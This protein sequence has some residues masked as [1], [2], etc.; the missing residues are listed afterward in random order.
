MQNFVPWVQPVC[1][2]GG[3]DGRSKQPAKMNINHFQI[4]FVNL[5]VAS[6]ET[7]NRSHNFETLTPRTRSCCKECFCL[8]R[9]S[10]MQP[11]NG[12]LRSSLCLLCCSQIKCTR[13]ICDTRLGQPQP[14]LVLWDLYLFLV[15]ELVSLAIS[16]CSRSKSNRRPPMQPQVHQI[17][18]L[19][20]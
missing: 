12:I 14:R 16:F 13:T 4:S 15:V 1:L 19:L 9:M 5:S 11:V 2:A 17:G 10:W 7:C 20:R 6:G 8:R 3:A 18:C